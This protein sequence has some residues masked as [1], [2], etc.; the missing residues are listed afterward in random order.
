MIYIFVCFGGHVFFG[1]TMVF[2]IH[3]RNNLLLNEW[4]NEFNEWMNLFWDNNS[5]TDLYSKNSY[6]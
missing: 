2:Y 3:S 5:D 4:M 1:Q 6:S